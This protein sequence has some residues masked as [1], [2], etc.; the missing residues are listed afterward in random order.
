MP[1][2]RDPMVLASYL[3]MIGQEND[4]P[5]LVNA[6]QNALAITGMFANCTPIIAYYLVIG[7]MEALANARRERDLRLPSGRPKCAVA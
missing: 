2:F 3:A 4:P 6:R 5:E 7:N 1:T